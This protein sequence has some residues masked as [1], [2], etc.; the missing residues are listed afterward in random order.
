LTGASEQ[1]EASTRRQDR[2]HIHTP[3]PVSAQPDSGLLA[4]LEGEL[5]LA[6]DDDDASPRIDR[7]NGSGAHRL[8]RAYPYPHDQP[9]CDWRED[10]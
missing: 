8:D 10:L 5:T 1:A 4:W 3:R 9:R 6:V 7:M 2:W